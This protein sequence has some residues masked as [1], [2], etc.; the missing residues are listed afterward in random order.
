MLKMK[1]DL[2][3][4]KVILKYNLFKT[5]TS[6]FYGLDKIIEKKHNLTK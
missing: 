6:D 3:Q 4:G 5:K 2:S 1:E